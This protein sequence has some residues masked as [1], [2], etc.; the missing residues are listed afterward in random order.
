MVR[1]KTTNTYG[2]APQKY[3]PTINMWL[4]IANPQY[5]LKFYDLGMPIIL[6]FVFK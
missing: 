3:I 5:F 1:V 6:M 2:K 4:G